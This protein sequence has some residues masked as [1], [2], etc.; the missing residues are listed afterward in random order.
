MLRMILP[1]KTVFTDLNQWQV[2]KI[3]D[4]INS[5][6]RENL[7]GRTPYEAALLKY[8]YQILNKLKLKPIINKDEV[9]LTP[10][11]ILN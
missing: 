2:K 8:D 1:K 9:N 11:L 3:V 4:N 5:T 7:G 10:H 6:P